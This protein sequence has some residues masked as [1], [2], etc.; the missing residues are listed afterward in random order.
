M[1]SMSLSGFQL[2]F[3]HV[4]STSVVTPSNTTTVATTLKPA[5]PENLK[6]ME[7]TKLLES[8]PD[9]QE[10]T[11]TP[12]YAS[13]IPTEKANGVASVDKPVKATPSDKLSSDKASETAQH[14][15]REVTGIGTGE[16]LGNQVETN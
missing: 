2:Y 15:R 4:P 16:E 1:I 9:K 11:E 14:A 13:K 12:G 7:K 8:T 3:F 5:M 6:Q 10:K